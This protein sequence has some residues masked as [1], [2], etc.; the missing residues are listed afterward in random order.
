MTKQFTIHSLKSHFLSQNF[1]IRFLFKKKLKDL[2][3][4]Q[5]EKLKG[6]STNE[7]VEVPSLIDL[8]Q[9]DLDR[10]VEILA[11]KYYRQLF[12]TEACSNTIIALN[13]FKEIPELYSPDRINFYSA[14]H[15]ANH[16]AHIYKHAATAW[17]LHTSNNI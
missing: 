12:Y 8:S 6:N 10:I 4:K 9:I 5:L 1:N 11:S 17:Q 3:A 7:N 13:P 14:P 2:V 15:Q 16:P